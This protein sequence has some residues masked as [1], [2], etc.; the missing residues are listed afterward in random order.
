MTKLSTSSIILPFEVIDYIITLKDQHEQYERFIRVMEEIPLKSVFKKISFIISKW[1][2]PTINDNVLDF[3]ELILHYTSSEERQHMMYYLNTCNCCE[4]HKQR[5]P[6][7]E[8]YNRGFVPHYPESVMREKK[9]ECNCRHFCRAL[10]RAENDI[11]M[12]F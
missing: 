7:L 12:D 2:K 5:K 1:E 10:C 3:E 11:V 9:C 4:D 8:H 6:T